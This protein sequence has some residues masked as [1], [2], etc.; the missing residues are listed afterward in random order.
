MTVKRG[1]TVT[2]F[3]AVNGDDCLLNANS[4]LVLGVDIRPGE[5]GVGRRPITFFDVRD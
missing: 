5:P 3:V 1:S 2:R 4:F